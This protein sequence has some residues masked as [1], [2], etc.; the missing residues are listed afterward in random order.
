MDVGRSGALSYEEW[1]R[2]VLSQPDVL[3][4]FTLTIAPQRARS[5]EDA[6]SPSA[7]QHGGAHRLHRALG[8]GQQLVNAGDAMPMARLAW[9]AM[10]RNFACTWTCTAA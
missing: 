3:S 7:N 1:A 9:Q 4:C 8:E 6:A 2:G 5:A 10:W